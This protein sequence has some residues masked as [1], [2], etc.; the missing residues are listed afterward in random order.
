[1]STRALGDDFAAPVA[2]RWLEDYVPGASYTYGSVTLDE[3]AIIEFA[4]AYDPQPFHTDPAAAARSIYG[5]L[6]ASGWHTTA[7]MMRV[8][9]DHV[10]SP[11]SSLGSPGCDELR[12]LKPVRAGDTLSVR[13]TFTGTRRSRS[14]PDRGFAGADIEILNQDDEVV[15]TLKTTLYLLARERE[16]A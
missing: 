4:R 2:D 15:M 5:G 9:V 13:I 14:R 11:A 6:I 16:S 10:I 3:A 1:V 8:L 12:W 7:V